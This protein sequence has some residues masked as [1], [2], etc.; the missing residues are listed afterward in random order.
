MIWPVL[1]ILYSVGNTPDTNSVIKPNIDNNPKLVS[2]ING[3]TNKEINPSINGYE[4][5][6]WLENQYVTS[7]EGGMTENDFN[8]VTLTRDSNNNYVEFSKRM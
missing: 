7:T 2:A 8:V 6:V 3:E 4:I 5:K 1:I